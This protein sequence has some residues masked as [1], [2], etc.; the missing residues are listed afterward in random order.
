[1][2]QSIVEPYRAETGG[3]CTI[4]LAKEN[5]NSHPPTNQVIGCLQT[6]KVFSQGEAVKCYVFKCILN[7]VDPQLIYM[8]V[9]SNAK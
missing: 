5:S 2:E 9:S 7:L 3:V 4:K 8:T 6:V 1:M